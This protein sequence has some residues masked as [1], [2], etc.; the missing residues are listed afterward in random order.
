MSAF[1]PRR[2][3]LNG[4]LLSASL[5][6]IVWIASRIV[7]TFSY[8]RSDNFEYFTPTYDLVHRLWLKGELPLW[9]QHQHLGEPLLGNALPGVFYFP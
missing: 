3:L 1:R 8:N 6:F 2:D 5:C 4:C 9:N 7:P